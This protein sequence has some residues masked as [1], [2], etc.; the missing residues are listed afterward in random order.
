MKRLIIV[1]IV[2]LAF[3]LLFV[4]V[5]PVLL[6]EKVEN[7]IN[8][9]IEKY[10]NG[11]VER[12][13]LSLSL[14]KRFPNLSVDMPNIIVMY[15]KS[16]NDTLLRVENLL[17]TVKPMQALFGKK[18]VVK[19]CEIL[20]PVLSLRTENDSV[21]SRMILTTEDK[22][23]NL[24]QSKA[25]NMPDI[26][27]FDVIQGTFKYSNELRSTHTEMG[28][29]NLHIETVK[30]GDATTLKIISSAQTF[31][32]SKNNTRYIKDVHLGFT[33]DIETCFETHS[34]VF[35]ENDFIF[36]NLHLQV[37]GTVK[38]LGNGW[39]LNVGLTGKDSEFKSL[40]A[41]LPESFTHEIPETSGSFVF[42]AKVQGVVT[43]NRLPAFTVQMSANDGMIRYSDKS[44]SINAINIDAAIDNRGGTFD[45]TVVNINHIGFDIDG[46]AFAANLKV[47]TPESNACFKGNMNGIID[48]S[49][50]REAIPHFDS[51]AFK[52]IMKSDVSIEGDFAMLNGEEY[53]KLKSDGTVELSNFEIVNSS[54]PA[55]LK[56]TEA[57][58]NIFPRYAE[59]T[60]F[61]GKTG[62]SDFA[63]EGKLEN[64]L[65]CFLKDG[66]LKGKLRHTSHFIDGNELMR[67]HTSNENRG[68]DSINGSKPQQKITIPDN[69]DIETNSRIDRIIFDKLELNNTK[70]VLKIADSKLMLHNVNTSL[71]NGTMTM[72]GAYS[73]AL[74]TQP[75]LDLNIALAAIDVNKAAQS[76]TIVESM[77]P[78]AQNA[79]GT[80]SGNLKLK[81][82]VDHGLTTVQSSLNGG[83][84]LKSNKIKIAGSNVQKALSTMLKDSRYAQ[85]DI[86]N[87]IVDFDIENGNIFIKPFEVDFSGKKVIV[88]GKQ[89]LDKTIDYSMKIP[90]SSKEIGR[91]AGLLGKTIPS[92]DNF[93][94]K[95]MITGTSDNPELKLDVEDVKKQL[96]NEYKNDIEK[97]TKA[98]E[99]LLEDPDIKK[100]VEDVG[101]RL[102]KLFE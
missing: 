34:F 25:F 89:M 61:K 21:N 36:N 19:K 81:G 78:I 27:E 93:I 10:I 40:L 8:I 41:L 38:K 80:V 39:N 62:K 56:I 63:L 35:G 60:S 51:L 72:N 100:K 66:T 82:V 4:A 15:G 42:N 68:N 16:E 50:L 11:T 86:N 43:S 83:G 17:L 48:F 2:V 30:K 31:S 75:T 73:A 49:A 52:G 76:F 65:S 1:V 85:T 101:N 53:E 74:T 102:R 44:K 12:G 18:I 46:N 88:A 59:L 14:F 20:R 64:Y 95:V 22:Q 90:V 79:T 71:L 33:A 47:V 6:R 26:V 24:P 69:M 13:E 54:F 58:L 57:R 55:G 91:F 32:F 7:N 70:G 77:L 28:E 3:I 84:N 9:G 87:L 29:V 96:E 67:L 99:K 37:D 5:A 94:V 97:A 92:G 23:S 98:V 45:S